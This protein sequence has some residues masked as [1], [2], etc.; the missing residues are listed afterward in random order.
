M[1]EEWF[2]EYIKRIRREMEE[3]FAELE[4][5]M[6]RPMLDYDSKCLLPLYE[7]RDAGDKIVVRVDLPGV[8]SVND[9]TVRGTEDKLLIEAK[10]SVSACFDSLITYARRSYNFYKLELTLPAPVDFKKARAVFRNGVLEIRLP[11]KVKFYRVKVE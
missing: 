10:M 11:K 6:T 1:S 5:R 4:E 8:R 9:I 2:F 3:L 7:I